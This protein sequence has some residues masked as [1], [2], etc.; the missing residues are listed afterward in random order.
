[1]PPPKHSSTNHLAANVQHRICSRTGLAITA[2]PVQAFRIA[3]ESYGPLAPPVREDTDDR[4]SW[5]RFDTPG[6]TIYAATEP[7]TAFME[8]LAPYRTN[9]N[10]ERR[11]LQTAADAAGVTLDK[12]WDSVTRDWEELGHMKATW[13][14]WIFRNGRIISALEFPKGWWIDIAAIETIQALPQLFDGARPG[15]GEAYVDLTT[16]DLSGFDRDKTTAIAQLLRSSVELDDG[17]LPLGIEFTS[18]FGHPAGYMG[19][20]YAY[21]MRDVDA[22]LAEPTRVLSSSEIAADDPD[23]NRALELC[24]IKSR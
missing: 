2:G 24:K 10:D 22:H 16:A 21:W 15:S 17:T 14:P 5:G 20:C 1:M 23:F 12:F 3:R 13:L 4:Q 6:R 9:V 19:K 18:K 11:A 8:M 7:L